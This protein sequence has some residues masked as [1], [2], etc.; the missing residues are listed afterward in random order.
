FEGS[1]S[2][3]SLNQGHWLGGAQSPNLF[4]QFSLNRRMTSRQT[5]LNQLPVAAACGDKSCLTG[6]DSRR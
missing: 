1:K 6:L 4:F 5:P 2:W 3:R